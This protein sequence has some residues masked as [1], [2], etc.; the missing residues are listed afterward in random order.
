MR[1]LKERPSG[2]DEA[3]SRRIVRSVIYL[4]VVFGLAPSLVN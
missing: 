2:Q 3:S 4:I 1:S